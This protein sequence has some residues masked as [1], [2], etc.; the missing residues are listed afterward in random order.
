[1]RSGLVIVFPIDSLAKGDVSQKVRRIG[2]PLSGE[3]HQIA[4]PFAENLSD[5]IAKRHLESVADQFV[6]HTSATGV[7]ESSC[8]PG[9]AR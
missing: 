4:A 2:E 7:R 3:P 8:A 5:E 1:M 6:C 9:N